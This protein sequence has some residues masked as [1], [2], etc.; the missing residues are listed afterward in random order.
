MNEPK[1]RN[2]IEDGKYLYVRI[3]Y[4]GFQTLIRKVYEDEKGN[5]YIRVEGVLFPI[6]HY[7]KLYADIKFLK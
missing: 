4:G 6:E 1:T 5:R 7:A 2:V 3:K